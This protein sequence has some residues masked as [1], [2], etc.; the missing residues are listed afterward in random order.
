MVPGKKFFPIRVLFLISNLFDLNE[1]SSVFWLL[2]GFSHSSDVDGQNYV[3]LFALEI[4]IFFNLNI[5]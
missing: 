4:N 2:L 1:M 3:I 5:V